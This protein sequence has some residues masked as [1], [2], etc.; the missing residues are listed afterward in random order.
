MDRNDT[1][2]KIK[3]FG[4]SQLLLLFVAVS[5]LFIFVA[6]HYGWQLSQSDQDDTISAKPRIQTAQL[7]ARSGQFSA[8]RKQLSPLL[9]N[10]N[11]SSFRLAKWLSWKLNWEESMQLAIG[12]AAR[13]SALKKLSDETARM[14]QLGGWSPA[15][16]EFL[17][18]S[19]AALGNQEA[20]AQA[21]TAAAHSDPSNRIKFITHAAAF[22]A[23][24][25]NPAKAGA[26]Y[27]WLAMQTRNPNSQQRFFLQGITLSEGAIGADKT[28]ILAQKAINKIPTLEQDT[29]VKLRM[30]Q[31]A[32]TAGKP[33]VAASLLLQA[34]NRDATHS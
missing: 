18:K 23:A 11:S 13:L 27:F 26:I 34:L 32:I 6:M 1:Q 12:S 2:E 5:I 33:Q 10:R 28:L 16:W 31:L 15:Q 19:S 8:A 20:S 3:V 30:A 24:S 4:I 7:L 25:G 9:M 21:W 22:W 14:I 17:A 29:K